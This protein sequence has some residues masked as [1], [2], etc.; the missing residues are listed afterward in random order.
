ML[1]EERYAAIVQ[2]LDEKKAATVTE[3]AAWLN[4]SESTIRRDLNTL[5]EI[6]KINKVHGGAMAL[7][8][9]ISSVDEDFESKT[10]KNIAEKKM[11]A[12]YAATLINDNDIVFIDAGTTTQTLIDCLDTSLKTVFVTN[13]I[14]NAKKLIQKG[15]KAYIIGGQM[16]LSTQAV[17]GAEA[18]NSLRQYN[19]TKCFLGTNGVSFES[20]CTTPD[21]EEALVKKEAANRSYISYV[22]TDHTKFKLVSAI[23]FLELN[24]ACIITDKLTD[25]RLKD[26]T[27][28]KEV[29]V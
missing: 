8:S 26:S 19:F 29:G 14:V 22:L 21:L 5:D 25:K 27:V 15:F 6:G 12:E 28:I 13:G 24:R 3:L 10:H 1:S 17:I 11:I 7:E 16:K 9:R 20:G 18:I 23:T 2:F 4:T